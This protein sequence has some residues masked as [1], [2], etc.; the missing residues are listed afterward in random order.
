MQ[1]KKKR[2]QIC[3]GFLYYLFFFVTKI[4]RTINFKLLRERNIQ[5]YKKYE[6]TTN[7]KQKHLYDVHVHQYTEMFIYVYIGAS[8]LSMEIPRLEFGLKCHLP[9]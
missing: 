9:V 1:T 8:A 5:M 3:L 7:N 4:Q 6:T 2:N